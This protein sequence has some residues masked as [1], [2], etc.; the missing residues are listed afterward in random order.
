MKLLFDFAD[1]FNGKSLVIHA[2]TLG[3]KKGLLTTVKEISKYAVLVSY[4]Q[5]NCSMKL[6]NVDVHGILLN[7]QTSI[8]HVMSCFKHRQ[9]YNKEPWILFV[10]V[11]IYILFEWFI[12]N[13]YLEIGN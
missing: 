3:N 11:C 5:E 12:E 1:Y 2:D 7:S 8:D 4:N 6:E 10:K 9:R 13:F